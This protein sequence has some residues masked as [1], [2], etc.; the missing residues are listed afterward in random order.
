MR[1]S[2][3]AKE[4]GKTSKEIL[5]ILQKNQV[6]DKTHSSNISEEHIQMVKRILT[7]APAKAPQTPA[8]ASSV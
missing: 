8:P 2:E 7:P 5:D 4:L 1:V 3:L 6:S